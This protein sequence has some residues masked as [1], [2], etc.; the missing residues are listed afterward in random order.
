MTQRK[1]TGEI[2]NIEH[3]NEKETLK[4]KYVRR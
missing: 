2:L 4:E 1:H 3:I